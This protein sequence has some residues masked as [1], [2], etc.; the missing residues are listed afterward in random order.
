MNLLPLD[1]ARKMVAKADIEPYH[2]I[3][4]PNAGDGVLAAEI[5]KLMGV[6]A[7]LVLVESD[8]AR[9]AALRTQSSS[10]RSRREGGAWIGCHVSVVEQDFL[11]YA[12]SGK[13]GSFNRIVLVPPTGQ[14][15]D[16]LYAKAALGLLVPGGVLVGVL[17]GT[18]P[19][20]A[21][22]ICEISD[23]GSFGAVNVRKLHRLPA[24]HLNDA[25]APVPISL[26]E[27]RTGFFACPEPRAS[28]ARRPR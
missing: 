27:I 1:L 17:E 19:E 20:R 24:A 14:E 12:A 22:A 2:R 10:W 26:I 28:S 18:K 6:E 25:G 23:S 7:G 8:P 11:E 21:E 3:L 16:V 4:V 5:A 15:Q 9:T 13:D